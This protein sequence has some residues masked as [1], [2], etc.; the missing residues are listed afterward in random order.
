[1]NTDNKP[2]INPASNGPY[3]VKGLNKLSNKKGA[4]DTEETVALCRC[5]KSSNKPFCDGAHAKVNFTSDNT[6][7]H[8]EDKLDKYVGKEITVFDNRKICAHAGV[9][10]DNLSSVFRMKQEPWID[11]DAT[12]VDEIIAVIEKCPS[13]ALSYALKGADVAE[14]NHDTGIFIAPNGP[15]VLLGCPDLQN[16][17]WNEGASQQQYTLC[18]CGASK[19]KPFCDGSHWGIEFTDDDN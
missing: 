12:S 6:E 13:G 9:C 3:I 14:Q 10:T 15:Y 4:V 18:R 1:M 16:T 8:L 7:P 17:K 5:G 2:E 11:S 19:N